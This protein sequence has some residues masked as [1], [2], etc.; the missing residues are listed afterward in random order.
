MNIPNLPTDNLYKFLALSGVVIFLFFNI[1]PAHLLGEIKEE[2]STIETEKGELIFEVTALEKIQEEVEIDLE[3]AKS[4]ISKYQYSDT[5][6]SIIIVEELKEQLRNPANRDYLE[7]IFKHKKDI[8]PS[9]N[10][11]E[12]IRAKTEKIKNTK[13]EILL[14]LHKITRKL[15]LIEDKNTEA[16]KSIWKWGAGY[17]LGIMMMFFGFKLWYSRVQ[18]PLDQKLIKEIT[19][20]NNTYT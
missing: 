4:E 16:G 11:Q 1:Y 2:I 5:L 17:F 6:E 8:L 12:E 7:F 20:P 9:L 18:K 15:K 10:L 3:E 19:E 14:R 13:N